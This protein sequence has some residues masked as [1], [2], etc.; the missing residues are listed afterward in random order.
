MIVAIIVCFV[1]VQPIICISAFATLR[2]YTTVTNNVYRIHEKQYSYRREGGVKDSRSYYYTHLF[3]SNGDQQQDF[4]KGAPS[5]PGFKPGQFDKLSK[6]ATSTASNRPIV[7]EYD[8]DGLWLWTQWTGTIREMTFS[9]VIFS[10]LWSIVVDLY[11][12]HHYT[13]YLIAAAAGKSAFVLFCLVL[14]CVQYEDSMIWLLH[15]AFFSLHLTFDTFTP[16][17][18]TYVTITSLSSS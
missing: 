7:A 9:N 5:T 15:L 11:T 18:L 14:L 6:W 8:P 10:L 17:A 4:F 3:S 16:H 2:Q 1:Y 12:Y 13:V